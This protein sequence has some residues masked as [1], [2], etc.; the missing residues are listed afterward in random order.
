MKAYKYITLKFLLLSFLFAEMYDIG[1]TISYEHQN[2]SYDT[3]YSGNGY[4]L[5]D[6]W[7]LADWNG[8][9]NGGNYNVIV[10]IMSASW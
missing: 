5:G 9:I 10:L 7:K 2:L 8:E 6:G 4:D 1:E 3:C